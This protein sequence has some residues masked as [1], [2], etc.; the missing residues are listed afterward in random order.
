MH[1]SIHV[2]NSVVNHTLPQEAGLN[3][4]M[5]VFFTFPPWPQRLQRYRGMFN[6]LMQ[7]TTGLGSRKPTPNLIN[8][9]WSSKQEGPESYFSW[10]G[11]TIPGTV[12]TRARA[13][14]YYMHGWVCCI[15]AETTYIRVWHW[16]GLSSEWPN[17]LE[18][19]ISPVTPMQTVVSV[20]SAPQRASLSL[21]MRILLSQDYFSDATLVSWFS[22]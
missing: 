1:F 21:V 11:W 5:N 3:K 6:L 9:S 20:L 22:G 17:K 14:V 16:G 4:N 10:I 7:R 2:V 13:I 18:S 15:E 12:L 19:T 8:Q